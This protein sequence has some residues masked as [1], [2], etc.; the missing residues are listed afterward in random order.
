V[1]DLN[2]EIISVAVVLGKQLVKA[3]RNLGVAERA[4][5]SHIFV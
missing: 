5:L 3:E 4:L 1:P 2:R